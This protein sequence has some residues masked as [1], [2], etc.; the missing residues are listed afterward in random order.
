MQNILKKKFKEAFFCIVFS[1]EFKSPWKVFLN[2]KHTLFSIHLILQDYV[3][4]KSNN[5]FVFVSNVYISL[6]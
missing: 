2:L 4:E 1:V 3:D 5:T 6:I